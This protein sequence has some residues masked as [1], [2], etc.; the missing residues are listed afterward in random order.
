MRVAV[1]TA[2]AAVGVILGGGL[3]TAACKDDV[4]EFAAKVAAHPK[5]G[6]QKTVQKEL[7]KAQDFSTWDESGCFN[8]LSR[9]KKAFAAQP[10]ADAADKSV[11]PVQPLNQH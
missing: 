8:A 6:D 5:V 3:A 10:A 11:Q 4:K 2:A 1:M 9:A 7:A